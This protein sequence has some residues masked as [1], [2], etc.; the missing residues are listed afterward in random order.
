MTAWT[1]LSAKLGAV[2]G[3]LDDRTTWRAALAKAVVFDIAQHARNR[4]ALALVVFF[5][6]A[7]IGLV[8][9]VLPDRRVDFHSKVAGRALSVPADELITIS[10]AINAVTLIVGFMMFAAVRR[11]GEFDQ[12]L[13]LAGYPKSAMLLAKLAGLLL[14][15]GA[16]AVYAAAVMTLHWEP[17]QVWLIAVSLFI[18]GLT[19]GGLGF[20]LGLVLSTELS[21][22]F[23][24]IMVSLVEV[25]LQNPVTNPSSD[26]SIVRFVPTFGAMQAGTTAGFTDQA[27]WGYCLLGLVWLTAFGSVSVTAFHRR[28][29]DHARR[30][31]AGAAPDLAVIT[32]TTRADGTLQ[33]LSA[34]GPVV[35]CADLSRCPAGCADDPAGE[36]ADEPAGAPAE[37]PAVPVPPARRTRRTA[38]ATGS[39]ERAKSGDRSRTTTLDGVKAAPLVR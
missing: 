6:P 5:I 36:A 4:L 19:Y 18:S 26:Q 7:W 31:D 24:I 25:M 14:V 32:L 35:R 3:A 1:T 16:V 39:A 10:G 34:T 29:K 9:A 20:V 22:M 17:R 21:G 23:V 8:K 12:R 15:S 11:S 37:E 13:V 38:A 28:T 30:A 2:R 33:V 27:S